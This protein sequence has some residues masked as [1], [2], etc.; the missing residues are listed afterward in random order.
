MEVAKIKVGILEVAKMKVGMLEV[1]ARPGGGGSNAR[2]RS[3]LIFSRGPKVDSFR[4]ISCFRMTRELV[5]F[6][7]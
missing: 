5:I 1:A 3:L 7:V 2:D 4:M 6:K